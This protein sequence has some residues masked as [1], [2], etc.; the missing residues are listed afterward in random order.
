MKVKDVRKLSM[1]EL[2]ILGSNIDYILE[3]SEEKFVMDLKTTMVQ[4]LCKSDIHGS[5]DCN[6]KD[7]EK[8]KHT[9]EQ[10][11]KELNIFKKQQKQKLLELKNEFKEHENDLLKI[12][13]NQYGIRDLDFIKSLMKGSII[14][15]LPKYS[16]AIITK[17]T[18]YIKEYYGEFKPSKGSIYR[19][20]YGISSIYAKCNLLNSRWSW[21]VYIKDLNNITR[22][23]YRY[24]LYISPDVEI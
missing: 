15:E 24:H 13:S 6:K 16:I 4:N 8:G 19:R 12:I 10:Y 18:G 3:D 1:R 11:R 17:S 14:F 2:E 9:L 21:T 20:E 22:T 5:T 23:Y 7:Y